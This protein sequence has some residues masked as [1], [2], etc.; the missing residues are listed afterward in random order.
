MILFSN[1]HRSVHF[2]SIA[3]SIIL[4]Q[5]KALTYTELYSARKRRR[6]GNNMILSQD[7]ALVA[8]E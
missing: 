6:G 2:R 7:K 1:N 3:F 5:D 4:S 8:K